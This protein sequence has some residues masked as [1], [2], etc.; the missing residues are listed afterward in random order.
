MDEADISSA[1]A[2]PLGDVR[3]LAAVPAA[4]V[5]FRELRYFAVLCE[6]LHFG[7]A[8]ERLHISQSP[9]SQ[10]IAQL[11]RKVGARLLDRSSRH[12]QLTPAGEVLREHTERLLRELEDA[13]GATRRA[14][15]GETGP[16]R[17]VAE[18]VSHV[19]V[20]PGLRHALDERLPQLVVDVAELAG[21][22]V[23]EA[24][25]HGGADIGLMVCAPRRDDIDIA[26]LRRDSPVA[27]MRRGHPLADREEVT[28]ADLAEHTL[29]LW[30]RDV[31]KGAHD[32]VLGMFHGHRPASTRVT[33]GYSGA[34]WDAMH[35][36]GFAV[37][38]AS[39]AV[40]GDFA[41]VRIS[42]GG[43]EFTMSLVWSKGTPPAVLSA[44]LDAADAA[45]DASGWR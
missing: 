8:A 30:P 27:V 2:R 3:R 36:D 5:E 7:R 17:I 39:A 18:P 24:V 25:L 33:D 26:L 16:L 12:V 41:T 10:T 37:V 9:L 15:G 34:M 6:E 14:G 45:A 44:L 19:A 20:L 21:D 11:E 42:D 35:A 29:V 43:I 13:V 22:D 4:T 23:V 38:P 28:V 32:L 1:S 40:S 31:A